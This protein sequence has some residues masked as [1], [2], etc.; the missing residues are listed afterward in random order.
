VEASIPSLSLWCLETLSEQWEEKHD[1]SQETTR[2]AAIDVGRH[3]SPLRGKGLVIHNWGL[4][5]T[6][7]GILRGLNWGLFCGVY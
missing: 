4:M 2:D 3:V 6:C 5:R 7:V 1:K